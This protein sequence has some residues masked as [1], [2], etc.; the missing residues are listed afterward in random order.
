MRRTRVTEA[1]QEADEL[2]D[3]AVR[4]LLSGRDER[5]SIAAIVHSA[6]PQSTV[7]WYFPLKGPSLRTELA[8]MDLVREQLVDRPLGTRRQVGTVVNGWQLLEEAVSW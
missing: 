3:L 2:V 1:R 8:L 5:F 4:Q 7:F 6:S